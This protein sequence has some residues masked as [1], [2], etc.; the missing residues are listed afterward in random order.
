MFKGLDK[1]HLEQCTRISRMC[2][3]GLRVVGCPAQIRVEAHQAPAPAPWPF[4]VT[5]LKSLHLTYITITLGE[6]RVQDLPL[7]AQPTDKIGRLEFSRTGGSG[8]LSK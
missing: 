6:G 1:D 5:L 7:A 8:G 3:V 4:F 2:T